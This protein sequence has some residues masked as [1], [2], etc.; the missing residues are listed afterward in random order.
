MG[1]PYQHDE[2]HAKDKIDNRRKEEDRGERE[3]DPFSISGL[4]LHLHLLS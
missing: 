4:K 3:E 2:R 1:N